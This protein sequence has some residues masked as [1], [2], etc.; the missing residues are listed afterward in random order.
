[1]RGLFI[2]RGPLC[3][4]IPSLS[5]R[6]VRRTKFSG[7]PAQAQSAES[8]NKSALRPETPART[9]F[10]PSPTGYLHLGSLRTALYN[11]LLARATGGQFLLRIEDTDQTRRVHDAETRLYEDLKWAGL[12]YDEGPGKENPKIGSYRQSE[13]VH[14][15]K[16]HAD[17]LLEKGQAYR[18][19]CTPEDLDQMKALAMQSGNDTQYNGTCSH[20]PPDVAQRR[21]KNGEP[22][23]IRFKSNGVSPVVRDL[24]YGSYKKPEKEDDFIIVKRDGQP[25]YHFANVVDDHHMEITHV[26]RGAEWL[27]STPRH[28]ALYD[29]FGWHPPQ[30]AHVGLLVDKNKQKLSKRHGDIDIASWR[31]KGMLPIALLNY[32]LLLGWSP[33]KGQKGQSDVMD[34]DEM[35]SKFH[36]GFTKGNIGVNDKDAFINKGHIRRLLAASSSSSPA[37]DDD[38][39]TAL[40]EQL[41]PALL[42]RIEE[43]EKARQQQQ[44]DASVPAEQQQQQLGK[45]I[46]DVG[47]DRAT[48][49]P[50]AAAAAAAYMKRALALDL[51]S[52]KDPAS[53]VERNGY[54]VWEP[55]D[56][57]YAAFFA[58]ELAAPAE[59]RLLLDG[60]DSPEG[61]LRPARTL[62]EELHRRLHE[63]GGDGDDWTRARLE[64]K[65]N[66]F[67]KAVV[68]VGPPDRPFG[69]QLL[70]YVVAAGRP[71]P[72]L[73]PSLLVLGRDRTLARADT[74]Y[75]FARE[76][77]PQST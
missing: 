62:V 40:V 54:L 68:R 4:S 38:G 25:T 11:F 33:G 21:A 72:A 71:G 61:T 20:I 69:Q 22:H 51:K 7:R 53:Y 56:A 10:A 6:V 8:S 63:V 55:P 58:R 9:R 13:R 47:V 32:V 27:V 60:D 3:R 39:S 70:R 67:L 30:F 28:V 2:V 77:T 44:Q 73:I 1:M 16:G 26:I 45:P 74:A 46:V 23:C 43:V 37:A 12:E 14:I 76:L 64:E 66:P 17:D 49:A 15:Y 50:S 29:A 34:M 75:R 52:Y 31:A 19:F 65:L 5:P 35:I 24:V 36:L 48:A 59:F 57:A 42:Q 41:L 18:C